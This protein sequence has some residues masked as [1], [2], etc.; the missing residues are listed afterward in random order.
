MAAR[1]HH[2]VGGWTDSLLCQTIIIIIVVIV[3]VVVVVYYAIKQQMYN[4]IRKNEHL[5]TINI[6]HNKEKPMTEHHR[7]TAYN[8]HS[9]NP[10]LPVLR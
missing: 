5:R 2:G 8:V 6:S 9:S 7:K 4:R 3:V 1:Q 10:H